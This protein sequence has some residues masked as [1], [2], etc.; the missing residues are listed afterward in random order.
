MHSTPFARLVCALVCLLA[1]VRFSPAAES[2]GSNLNHQASA[3]PMQPTWDQLMNGSLESQYV[4]VRGM[5]GSLQNRKD[6]WSVVELRTKKGDLKVSLY[7]SGLRGGP[8]EKHAS[9]VVRLR[10]RL[11]VDRDTATQRVVAGQIRMREAELIVEQPAPEDR[12]AVP[13]KT[14]AALTRSN[15]DYDAFRWVK[16]SGQVIHIKSRLFFLMDNGDGLRFVTDTAQADL[17]PGD[18]V[19]V[20]GYQD[21]LSAAAPVLRGA[22]V[23]KTGHAALPE[24]KQ[25][26]PDELVLPSFDSKWVRVEGTLT[27]LK[28]TGPDHVLEIH[29]GPWRFW[30]RLNIEKGNLPPLQLGSRLELTGTYCAQGGYKVIGPDVA[31]LDL[32]LNS[33]SGIKVLA[34]PTWWTLQRL[35][36]VVGVLICLL[37][38]TALWITLLHRK[39]RQRTVEL[40][41]EIQERQLVE[42]RH[43]MELE[44]AR[45]AQDLHDELGSG[46]TEIGMLAARAKGASLSAETR[47]RY[48]DEMGGRAREMVVALDEIVWAM[49]PAHNS[50]SSLVSYFSIYADRFLGLANVAWRLENADALPEQT[51]DSPRRH[52]LFMVFK[53]ALNNVVRHAAAT[54]VCFKIEVAGGELRLEIKDDGCGLSADG[55]GDNANGI[56]NMKAR[57]EKLGGRFAIASTP[58]QGTTVQFILPI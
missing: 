41:A 23:R 28:Q 22:V 19:E 37:A 35:L 17:Q 16:V 26:T 30:A 4:E 3:D 6:G 12:F 48:L 25:V 42:N 8:L 40:A 27:D 53:E 50:L 10:G 55:P 11:L 13:G 5:L 49:N 20:V 51:L 24:P 21:V 32:L 46:I 58:G 18:V 29:S 45:I 54:E 2:P 1:W 47:E 9:A 39:V 36:V 33:P 34:T 38:A 43:A 56:A 7:R 31:A 52:Q 14:V 57:M 15:P 44:R